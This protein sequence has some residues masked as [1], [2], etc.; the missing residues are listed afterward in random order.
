MSGAV[1]LRD[2]VRIELSTGETFVADATEPAA[3]IVGLSHAHGDHLYT[4]APEA[5][6]CSDVT[7]RLANARREDEGPLTRTTHPRVDQV[8]AGHVPG[9]R[10]TIVDDPDGTTYLYTGDFS[11]R[12]RFVLD[13]FD[14]AAVAD[15]YDVDVLITETTYG[16]P[17]YVFDDQDVLEAR[18]V[19]WLDETHET[20]VLL[21]GYTLGRAQELELLVGRS[22]R[23]RLFVTDATARLNAIIEDACDVD[24]GAERYEEA[25]TLGAGDA[26]LL[27]AQT[28]RL[29]F[30]DSIAES[31]G[32]LKAG[33]SG[34][35]IEESF[36]YRGSYDETFVLSDHSDFSELVD[37]VETLEPERVYTQHGFADAF[38]T[39]LETEFDLTARSLKNNQT[40]LSDF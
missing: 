23:E 17:K 40:A 36:K 31:T 24:F 37:T 35:A 26:L 22:D 25:T 39:H 38:A 20:P 13:G 28:N 21:F 32:A 29:S 16:E 18:I 34:W 15:E 27:P 19:D 12:S 2:G 8:P 3:D 14:A 1:S 6:V 10:A 5:V 11:P 30:V 9:S 7:A 33:F 4:R